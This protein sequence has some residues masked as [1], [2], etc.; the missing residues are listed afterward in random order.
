M[1]RK[2]RKNTR[3]RRKNPTMKMKREDMLAGVL[4]ILAGYYAATRM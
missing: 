4:G 1:A 2:K 3:R